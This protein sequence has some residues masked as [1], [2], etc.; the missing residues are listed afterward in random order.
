MPPKLAVMALMHKIIVTANLMLRAKNSLEQDPC[1]MGK[2]RLLSLSC[3]R[4]EPDQRGR[5]S[6][7]LSADGSI[8]DPQPRPLARAA[9]RFHQTNPGPQNDAT[10]F[11][12]VSG[13][14]LSA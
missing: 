6:T 13:Q 8:K 7:R 2:P 3:K 12:P 10:E 4:P 5:A 14:G 1:R 9:R 11:E